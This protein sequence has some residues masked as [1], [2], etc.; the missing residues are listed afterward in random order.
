MIFETVYLEKL[1]LDTTF[2]QK[3]K[4]RNNWKWQKYCFVTE[5][6]F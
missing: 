1:M 2:V 4:G 3:K 6:K 5:M